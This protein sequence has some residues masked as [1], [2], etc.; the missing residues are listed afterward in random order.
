[1]HDTAHSLLSSPGCRFDRKVTSEVWPGVVMIAGLRLYSDISLQL[2]AV[3]W[4]RMRG[5]QPP[6]WGFDETVAG[7]HLHTNKM[8]S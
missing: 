7:I 8:M 2:A 5:P 4:V 3:Y 1:M 6:W